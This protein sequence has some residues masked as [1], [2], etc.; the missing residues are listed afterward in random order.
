LPSLLL[1]TVTVA[2]TIG[3]PPLSRKPRVSWLLIPLLLSEELQPGRSV[4]RLSNKKLINHWLGRVAPADWSGI[5][6]LL[7][8]GIK[9][10]MA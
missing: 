9:F 3:T 7:S 2:D 8:C 6:V 4:L 1:Y 10:R 5:D